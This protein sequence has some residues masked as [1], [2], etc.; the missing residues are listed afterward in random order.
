MGLLLEKHIRKELIEETVKTLNDEEKLLE[1]V[2]DDEN[3]YGIRDLATKQITDNELLKEIVFDTTDTE[4]T[5]GNLFDIRRTAVKQITDNETLYKIV[6]DYYDEAIDTKYG[7][8]VVMA[9]TE[10]INDD[11]LLINISNSEYDEEVVNLSLEKLNNKFQD[12]D[13]TKLKVACD[14]DSKVKRMWAVDKIDDNET[15]LDVAMNAKYLDVREEALSKITI[16]DEKVPLLTDLI[17]KEREYNEAKNEYVILNIDDE[18]N[19]QDI[20]DKASN[21]G[22][23]YKKIGNPKKEKFYNEQ[24]KL[25][26]D[27]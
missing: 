8:I 17:N 22:V 25:F 27:N 7:L 21:L 9:A 20:V 18:E 19:K 4:Y 3:L 24:C 26:K 14:D 1:I 23:E 13:K 11:E 15:L 16:N 6:N 2:K 5:K 10:E 12:L